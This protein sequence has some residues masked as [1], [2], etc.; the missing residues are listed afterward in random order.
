MRLWLLPST[1]LSSTPTW[2]TPPHLNKQPTPPSPLL[3]FIQP[4]L[5][6]PFFS[7]IHLHPGQW[8]CNVSFI[9]QS[10]VSP[11]STVHIISSAPLTHIDSATIPRTSVKI[12]SIDCLS[13]FPNSTYSEH[14]EKVGQSRS[15]A[16]RSSPSSSTKPQETVPVKA[17]LPERERDDLGFHVEKEIILETQTCIGDSFGL[18][19]T[20]PFLHSPNTP[21]E[22]FFVVSTTTHLPSTSSPSLR[23]ALYFYRPFPPPSPIPLGPQTLFPL[24]RDRTQN[25]FHPRLQPSLVLDFPEEE[26]N[27]GEG[28]VRHFRSLAISPDGGGWIVG[29][30]DRGLRGVWREVRERKG[31]GERMEL[32]KG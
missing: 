13:L 27:K 22:P 5:L 2:P 28:G 18:L 3:P 16:Y 1:V 7:T 32:E 15:K 20:P 19:R 6:F 23:P 11:S 25:D 4:P 29:V 30:G 9:D 10:L 14:L 26:E 21:S 24:N 31:R 8:P 12:S 17:R